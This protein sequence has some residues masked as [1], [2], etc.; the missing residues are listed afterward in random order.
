MFLWSFTHLV[1]GAVAQGL[2]LGP[3]VSAEYSYFLAQRIALN[4]ESAVG[5]LRDLIILCTSPTAWIAFIWIN[6]SYGV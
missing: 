1:N 4:K 2:A 3:A 6:I 5:R